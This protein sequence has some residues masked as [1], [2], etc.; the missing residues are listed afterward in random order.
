[1]L[2]DKGVVVIDDP[3]SSLDKSSIFQIFSALLREMQKNSQRQYF[4]L[5]HNLEFYGHLF[6]GVSNNNCNLYQIIHDQN[7]S[8]ITEMDTFLRN[9][10]SD[11]Q[12]VMSRLWLWSKKD[13]Y[14][15]DDAIQI[16]N[17]M[18]RCWET[19]LYF[20]FSTR[21]D[22]RS[23]LDKA[24]SEAY[25]EKLTSMGNKPPED[26]INESKNRFEE[27]KIAMYCFLNDGSHEY[28][29][30]DSNDET[31]LQHIVGDQLENFFE[32]IKLLDKHHFIQITRKTM[33]YQS[34]QEL[35]RTLVVRLQELGF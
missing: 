32:I 8:K 20:K 13:S 33:K 29:S 21:G 4:I 31:M 25:Q 10:K 35:E 2:D 34:E 16:P 11:Y 3:V 18:R 5:T 1:M 27:N 22:L 9:F 30:V 17:L 19:F 6:R 23:M 14:S 12:Y 26:K 24:Y 15:I 28:N 7:G